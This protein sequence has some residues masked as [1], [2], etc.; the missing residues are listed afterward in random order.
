MLHTH[1]PLRPIISCSAICSEH[2]L[3][4]QVRLSDDNRGRRLLLEAQQAVPGHVLYRH[5][6]AVGDDYHVEVSICD[7]HAVRGFDDLGEDMLNRVG[8]EVSF[9]FGAAVVI[10]VYFYTAD[11]DW[12][13]GAFGPVDVLG[14]VDGGFDVGAVEIDGSTFGG[15]DELGG[16]AED[17]PEERALLVDFVDVKAWVIGQGGIVDHVEDVAVGFA[18]VVEEYGGLVSRRWEGEVF[19]AE[20]SVSAG[21]VETFELGDE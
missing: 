9:A 4:L 14:R 18:G 16:E 5:K 20:G 17:V 13:D 7:K 11:E 6:G 19:V 3:V 2:S 21:F 1:G 10:A 12:V 8:A 15:V